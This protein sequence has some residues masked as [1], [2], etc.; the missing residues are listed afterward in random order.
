MHMCTVLHY[1]SPYKGQERVYPYTLFPASVGKKQCQG[2]PI[3]LPPR[4]E[5]VW[6]YTLS[7]LCYIRVWGYTLSCLCYIGKKECGGTLLPACV[8]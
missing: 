2:T 6:G 4:Q 1:H 3:I 5:R 8:I 7:C